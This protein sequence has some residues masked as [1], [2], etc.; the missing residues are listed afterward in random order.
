MQEEEAGQAVVV[1]Q[2][3]L[4]VQA[5]TGL[6]QVAAGRRSGA[7]AGRGR[8]GTGPGRP[9]RRCRRR[10]R[11]SCSRG[12][13]RGRSGSGR[14]PRGA[15]RRRRGSGKRAA[16]SAG[17]RS[18][19]SRLPRRSRSQASSVV[20]RRIATRV[21]CRKARR[22]VV[23][24]DIAGGDGAQ[25]LSSVGQPASQAVTAGVAAPVGALQL[26]RESVAAEDGRAAG[27]SAASAWRG[28]SG[29]RPLRARP[30]RR[31]RSRTGSAGRRR[32][33]RPSWSRVKW[34][35]ARAGRRRGRGVSRRQ[36]LR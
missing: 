1:D 34:R 22:G 26:D 23:G 7:P 27:G 17:A 21:S 19:D 14:P 25:A 36:R 24:V 31:G 5:A 13:W 32:G 29:R 8:C 28:R 18:N 3:Q 30:G 15:A 35:G 6:V 16:I 4:L 20:L 2:G 12:R 33:E 9:T 10:S 11:D